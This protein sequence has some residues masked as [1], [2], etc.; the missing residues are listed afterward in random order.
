VKEII[1]FVAA[2]MF[3]VTPAFAFAVYGAIAVKYQQLG[4]ETGVM[5]PPL[6]DELPAASGGRYNQFQWG[7]IFWRGDLGAHNVLY[8]LDRK[9]I[10]MGREGGF[11]YPVTDTLRSVREGM[12]NDFENGG[13]ICWNKTTG[14]AHAVYGLIRQKWV[15]LGRE[16][17]SCG[18]P[19]SDEFAWSAN[20]RSNF[21]YGYIIWSAN[22]GTRVYGCAGFQGD[23]KLNP[24]PN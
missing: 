8:P 11:G 9:W 21:E 6:S 17:G 12:C 10:G 20:R 4:G 14:T 3:V 22:S 1:I 16:R 13:T 2:L 19:T 23:V 15:Q 5:G 18:Y 24:V 7:Y